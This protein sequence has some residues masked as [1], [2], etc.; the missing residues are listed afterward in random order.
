MEMDSRLKELK[1]VSFSEKEQHILEAYLEVALAEGIES[2]TLQ[3]VAKQ[4]KVAY[5]TVHYYFGKSRLSI[6]ESALV[7]VGIASEKYIDQSMQTALLRSDQSSLA[8][9]VNAKFEWND[10]FPEYARLWCY[11]IYQCSR[12]AD[13][14]K[15]HAEFFDENTHRVQTFLLLE[16][17]KGR[18]PALRDLP[19]LA[20]KLYQ[21]I[22]GAM[23][24][25]MSASTSPKALKERK[26]LTLET[27]ET[28][29]EAHEK[30]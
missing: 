7:Y 22:M 12:D 5:A 27:V 18:Y 2:V 16:M 30:Q 29:I 25:T 10:K 8:A 21:V 20:A 14:R 13:Y 24:L 23:I 1:T 4:A 19:E 11:F 17:G 26:R 15:L 28:V 3:K 9:Y 6:L